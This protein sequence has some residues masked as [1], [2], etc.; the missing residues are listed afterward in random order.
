MSTKTCN[1][2]ETVQDRSCTVLGILHAGFV[3]GSRIRTCDWYRNQWP[4]ITWNGENALLRKK[5]HFTEPTISPKQ[6]KI[7]LAPFWGY[8]R[9]PGFCV[10]DPTLFHPN[11]VFP[12]DQIAYVGVCPS[13]NLKLISREIIFEVFQPTVCVLERHIQTDRRTYRRHTMA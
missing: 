9:L 7:G 4:W 10:H 8:C 3:E 2:S 13:I 5:N 1:I 11:F 6:C 12:L